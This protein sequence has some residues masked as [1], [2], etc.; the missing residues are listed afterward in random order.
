MDMLLPPDQSPA[1]VFFFPAQEPFLRKSP[2]CARA[3]SRQE[4][5]ITQESFLR[6]MIERV[7]FKTRSRALR[8]EE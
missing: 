1:A 4:A 5:F 3:L 8:D 6:K 7:L 2:S